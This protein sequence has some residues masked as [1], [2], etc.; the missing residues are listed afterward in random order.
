MEEK[1]LSSGAEKVERTEKASKKE[2]SPKTIREERKT[3]RMELIAARKEKQAKRRAE[4]LEQRAARMEERRKRREMLKNE[5]RTQRMKRKEREKRERIALMEKRREARKERALKNKELRLK[6]KEARLAERQHRRERNPGTGGWLAAVISLGV[7]TLV[8]S[9][10]VTAGAVNMMDMGNAA[11]SGYRS[12]FYE[13]VGLMDEMEND[14][15]KLQASSTLSE[16]RALA[17]ELLV[18]SS[19]AESSLERFPI[20]MASSSAMTGIINGTRSFSD[21]L[22]ASLAKGKKM[23]EEDYETVE[24]L[25]EKQA[26][27]KSEMNELANSMEKSDFSLLAKGKGRFCE[28]FK[29]LEEKGE[30]LKESVETNSMEGEEITATAGEDLL[31]RYFSDYG[32][33]EVERSGEAVTSNLSCYNYTLRDER[34]REIF[35]QLSKQ[36]KLFFFDSYEACSAKNYTIDRCEEIAEDFLESIG[37]DDMESVFVSESGTSVDFT[38]VYETE[39]DV[40]VYPD[41]VKVKVCETKGKVVGMDAVGYYNTHKERTLPSPKITEEQAL[42][43]VSV[44]LVVEDVEL[45]LIPL[46]GEETLCY[47]VH[48]TR[49]EK[50]YLVYLD[51]ETGE[52]VAIYTII[53]TK[54]G[55][56]L[57]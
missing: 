55:K 20:E 48:G 45:A 26:K 15:S 13:L 42:D 28:L 47:E 12:T 33:T 16:Q 56:I 37:L 40:L 3:K 51:A 1:K 21:E 9:S 50:E 6:K 19:L 53:N 18:N 39:S 8:L 31:Y 54:Q 22:L 25:Y 4:R 10:V 2:K 52:E 36:G 44:R 46:R 30:E 43:S 41:T 38:F 35:A 27:L 23:S 34:G 24:K 32:I 11:N 49:G 7:T 17:T 57:K 14:L 29:S 5:T